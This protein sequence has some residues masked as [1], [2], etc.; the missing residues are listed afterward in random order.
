[1]TPPPAVPASPSPQS[2]CT[3]G[4]TFDTYARPPSVGSFL[5]GREPESGG[6][7]PSYVATVAT[8]ARVDSADSRNERVRRA[9]RMS[10]AVRA[11]LMTGTAGLLAVASV[12]VDP[13]AGPA[14]ADTGSAGAGSG[15]GTVSVGVGTGTGSGGSGGGAPSGGGTGGG[16]GNS[17]W[18]C[19]YT[20]LT[21]NNQGGFPNGGPM[22]GAWYSVT[23]ADMAT[24]AQVTQTI[25]ITTPPVAVPQVDPR[26]LAL[27]AENSIRLPAP[28]IHLDPAGSSVVGLATWMWVDPTMWRDY[29]VTA[30]AG[31]VSATAV[32]HPVDVIWT[33]GDGGKVTCGGPGAAYDPA[34]SSAWQGTYCSHTYARTSIGQ[35]TPDGDPDHGQF[36]LVATVVWAVTWTAVGASGGGTLPTLTTSSTAPLRVAQI[37]SLNTAMGSLP[38]GRTIGLGSGLGFGT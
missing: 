16:S 15:G 14:V 3:P 21:L 4:A 19:T 30:T 36:G 27:Q 9:A 10:S 1:M 11:I 13:T 31:A 28:V 34:L 2:D 5:H 38:A 18:T 17:P 29:G 24:G 23:C 25:W 26:V 6:G 37:E 7:L 8:V 20:Y 22:P 12:L 32:A 35:P 33:T